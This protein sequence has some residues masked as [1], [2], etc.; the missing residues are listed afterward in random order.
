MVS[1]MHYRDELDDPRSCEEAT[2]YGAPPPRT[3]W[4][5]AWTP[6]A[7]DLEELRKWRRSQ[8]RLPPRFFNAKVEQFVGNP[9]MD[10]ARKHA[11]GYI[12]HF[13]KLRESG[14]SFVMTGRAGT[15]KTTLACA[16]GGELAERGYSCLYVKLGELIASVRDAYRRDSARSSADVVAEVI[17]PDLLILDEV[18][19][20]PGGNDEGAIIH[21]VL[22]GRYDHLKPTVMASNLDLDGLERAVGSRIVDR[23]KDKRGVFITF[24][25]ESLRR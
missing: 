10:V 12:T 13:E 4:T 9:R 11:E 16:I 19:V 14:T 2:P 3:P 21:R 6:G 25:W 8:A 15:G 1:T 23:L 7:A 18:G 17:E 20:Q 5:G 24:D 22:D